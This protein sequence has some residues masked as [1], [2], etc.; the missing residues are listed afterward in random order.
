MKNMDYRLPMPLKNNRKGL[1][2]VI[3]TLLIIL[4]SVALIAILAQFIVPFIR[5]SLNKSTECL[6]YNE[7]FTFQEVF[8]SKGGDLRYNCNT[9]NLTGFMVRAKTDNESGLIGFNVVLLGEVSSKRLD[10]RNLP[11]NG[12]LRMLNSGLSNIRVPLPGETMTYVYEKQTGEEQF[13]SAEIYPV[14]NS[15]RICDLGDTIKLI[16]CSNASML[17]IV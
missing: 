7:Y 2:E 9:D 1:S 13:I 8:S 5:D 17:R 11:R 16:A 6:N 3:A 14:L 12:P 15:G 10:I 4:L